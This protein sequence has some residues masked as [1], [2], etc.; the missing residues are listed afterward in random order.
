MKCLGVCTLFYVNLNL[1]NPRTISASPAPKNGRGE[2]S[3]GTALNKT[4]EP[5][6]AEKNSSRTHTGLSFEIS[7]EVG[8]VVSETVQ[9]VTCLAEN[10]RFWTGRASIDLKQIPF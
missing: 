8:L 2:C 3:G 4:N 6:P 5:V 1:C 9:Y 7:S 10:K